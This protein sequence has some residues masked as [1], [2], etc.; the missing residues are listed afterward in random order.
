MDIAFI[1]EDEDGEEG[2]CL[3]ESDDELMDQLFPIAKE[4]VEQDEIVEVV[5]EGGIVRA[6]RKGS[7]EKPEYVQT[8]QMSDETFLPLLEEHGVPYRAV[9][10]S[11]CQEGVNVFGA[12]R[13]IADAR[14]VAGPGIARSHQHF[15]D[16]GSL[17]TAP[18]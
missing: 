1:E 6:K 15:L 8:V 2:L 14:L 12:N 16:A 18:G 17:C 10:P 11:Q 5:F 9:Q 13:Y 7:E 4:L 3:I